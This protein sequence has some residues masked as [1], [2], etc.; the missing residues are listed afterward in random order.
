MCETYFTLSGMVVLTELKDGKGN[1]IITTIALDVKHSRNTVNA[2]SSVY[3]KDN[4]VKFIQTQV[5]A[6]NLL[7]ENKEKSHQWFASGQLQLLPETNRTDD[8]SS[9][10]DIQQDSKEVNSK[11]DG[12]YSAD[13]R[14]S[15]VYILSN[16]CFS[17]AFLL[18]LATT[19]W[20]S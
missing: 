17:L 11:E 19:L 13:S 20:Y 14:N 16:I 5:N 10:S 15:R 8:S 1:N 12:H 3:G 7:Y 4:S 18:G 9:A 6:G 2:I